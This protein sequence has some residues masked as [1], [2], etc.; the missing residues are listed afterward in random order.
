[1]YLQNKG[2]AIIKTDI[3][4]NVLIQIMN[5]FVEMKKINKKIIIVTNKYNNE[6]YEKYKC[7]YNNVN[8]VINN[9]IHDRFIIID[10]KHLYHVGASMKDLGKK[11]FGINKINNNKWINELLK[12]I[13]L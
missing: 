7:Q 13:G 4:V 10:R 3:A 8:V 12:E 9:G 1:M 6:D 5:A 11:C 2:S